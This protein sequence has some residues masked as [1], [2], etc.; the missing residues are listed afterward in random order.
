LL[1]L[2]ITLRSHIVTST[3]VIN[4]KELFS[5]IAIEA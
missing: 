4:L 3:Y 2:V 1:A 5:L